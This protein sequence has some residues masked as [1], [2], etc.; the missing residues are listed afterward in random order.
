VLALL[1]LA[2]TWLFSWI[3]RRVA[4]WNAPQAS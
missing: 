4:F 1:G 3:E 2:L